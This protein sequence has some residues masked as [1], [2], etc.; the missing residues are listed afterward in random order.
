MAVYNPTV[1]PLFLSGTVSQITTHSTY[2][3]ADEPDMQNIAPYEF[4]ITVSNISAQQT[5]SSE[6]RSV[7]K[8]YT[9]IDIKAGDW[10]TDA[11]GES[12]LRIVRAI[13]KS[14]GQI[15]FI[16]R[17][18]DAV[19]FKTYGQNGFS[20][21]QTIGFFEVSDDG[22]PA[23]TGA[24][25]GNFFPTALS[26]DKIQ[27]RFEQQTET[28][29]FR[30]EFSTAQTGFSVGDTITVD[31]VSGEFV[32]YNASASASVVPLGIITGF[33]MGN[34]VVYVK[35]FNKLVDNY[36]NP[37][38]LTGATG[39]VY[40]TDPAN[41]GKMTLT[42]TT[43]AVPIFL[44]VAEAVPTVVTSTLAN[45]LPDGDDILFINNV[46]VYSGAANT[47]NNTSDLVNLINGST[48]AHAVTASF[49]SV[50]ASVE[51]DETLTS[52][53]ESQLILSSDGGATFGSMSFDIA[54]GNTIQSITIGDPATVNATLGTNVSLIP[55]P[56]STQFLTYDAVAMAEILNA[57]FTSSGMNLVASTVDDG[58]TYINLKITATNGTSSIQISG[59][60]VDQFGQTFA[61][62]MGLATNTPATSGDFL[63]L[64]R[65]DGGD[66]LLTGNNNYWNVNGLTSSSF[67]SPAALLMLEGVKDGGDAVVTSTG[68]NVK[69]DLN[70]TALV[71]TADED[72]TGATI[73]YTPFSDSYVSVEVNGLEVNVGDGAK[74]E[75]SYFSADGGTTAKAIADIAAGDI[76][77]WMGSIAGYE[78]DET[79]EIDISYQASST[80]I[81]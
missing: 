21:D 3:H 51:T 78:L 33:T 64:T 6:V 50:F 58:E 65:A 41:P 43:G 60:D 15:S 81:S 42:K 52:F 79:D 75:P 11:S 29:T 49:N 24:P 46:P 34:T 35:P 53:G 37:A 44:Q 18:I 22:S 7:N 10:I 1:P 4:E 28:E 14:D 76:L 27:G 32:H 61:V 36:P 59:A 54:D 71:T 68:V 5:F 66:I 70:Q 23:I 62:G 39:N 45:Y 20:A 30:F 8:Q 47:V 57:V 2:P 26:I 80:D 16:A 67:G 40:Y 74:D 48:S 56:G 25:V 63:V 12:V 73:T 9:A 55:F 69:D 13:S 19:A 77:Y 17:D 38:L 72:S 31:T